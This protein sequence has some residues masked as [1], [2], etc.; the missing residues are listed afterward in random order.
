[1]FCKINQQTSIAQDLV[2]NV[3]TE[4]RFGS[5]VNLSIPEKRG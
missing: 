2:A 4:F 3:W 1:M 5:E